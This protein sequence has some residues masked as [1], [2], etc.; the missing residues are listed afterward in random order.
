LCWWAWQFGALAGSGDNPED[1]NGAKN[2]TVGVL[3]EMWQQNLIDCRCFLAAD[4]LK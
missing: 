1:A 4:L 2:Q 3:D